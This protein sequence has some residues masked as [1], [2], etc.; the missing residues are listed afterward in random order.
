MCTITETLKYIQEKD[1]MQMKTLTIT[2]NECTFI[3]VFTATLFTVTE[4]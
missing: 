1:H 2:T 4:T 3:L